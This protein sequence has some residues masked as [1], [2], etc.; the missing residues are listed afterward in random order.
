M[1]NAIIYSHYDN[2]VMFDQDFDTYE[3]AQ[4]AIENNIL[5]FASESYPPIGHIN[6]NYT[7]E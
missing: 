5:E 4:K 7:Q 6:K 2:E 3:K 1:Y